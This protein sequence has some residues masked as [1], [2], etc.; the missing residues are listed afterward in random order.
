MVFESLG[1]LLALLRWGL[2][3]DEPMTQDPFLAALLDGYDTTI[4]R[5]RRSFV[6]P[7]PLTVPEP[8]SRE[9]FEAAGDEWAQAFR[10]LEERARASAGLDGGGNGAAQYGRYRDWFPFAYRKR[11]ILDRVADTLGYEPPRDALV[12]LA[13]A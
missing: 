13:P 11:V 9:E 12:E 8:L 7:Q 5:L 4:D 1:D 10:R 6:G 2:P 3:P